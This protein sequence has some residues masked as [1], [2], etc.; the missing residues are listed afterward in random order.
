LIKE[1]L[2]EMGHAVFQYQMGPSPLRGRMLMMRR[3]SQVRDAMFR[4]L[5]EFPVAREL[6]AKQLYS[7]IKNA[8]PDIIVVTHDFLWAREI[9]KLRRITRAPLCLW[10]PDALSN[11]YKGHFINAK[12]DFLFF[13]DPYIVKLLSGVVKSKMFYLPECFSPKRHAYKGPLPLPYECELVTAGSQ[14]SWRVAWLSRLEEFDVRLYGSPAPFWGGLPVVNKMYQGLPVYYQDKARAFRSAKI[15]INN[16]HYAEI[17]GLNARAFEVAGAGAFQL[18]DWRPGLDQ[19][20]EDGKELVSFKGVED[21][22]AKIKHWLRCDQERCEIA[23]SGFRRAMRCHTYRL[24]LELMLATVG[25][26]ARGY[27][28][29]SFVGL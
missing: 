1:E 13:K 19:L 18:V 26:S 7:C 14:H 2:E 12:Y 23:Q 25:G 27:A 6:F 20:F 24:R 11:F 5:Q 8:A 4:S 21:L 29:P 17:W 16:L 10:F 28:L 9:E 3:A 22:K 15:V